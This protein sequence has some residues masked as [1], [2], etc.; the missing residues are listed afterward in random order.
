MVNI[1]SKKPTVAVIGTGF[2]TDL[3]VRLICFLM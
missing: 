2:V 3:M 1:K